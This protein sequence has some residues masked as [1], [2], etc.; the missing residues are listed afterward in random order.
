MVLQRRVHLVEVDAAVGIRFVVRQF[1]LEAECVGVGT[2]DARHVAVEHDRVRTAQRLRQGDERTAGHHHRRTG[3]N[4]PGGAVAFDDDEAA[5]HQCVAVLVT[6][7]L[8]PQPHSAS[9][10]GFLNFSD[11]LMPSRT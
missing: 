7:K 3:R 5:F 4:Q 2:V 1:H 6:E 10:F 11:A 8:S 9:A